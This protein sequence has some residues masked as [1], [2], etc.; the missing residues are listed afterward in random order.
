MN[1][2]CVVLFLLDSVTVSR[3][4][5]SQEI[6][7]LIG[8]SKGLDGFIARNFNQKSVLGSYLDPIS[9]KILINILATACAVMYLLPSWLVLLVFI[10]DALLI[11]GSVILARKVSLERGKDLIEQAA[12]LKLDSPLEIKVRYP[13]W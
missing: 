10:R 11:G 12:S 5:S 6:F 3:V 8:C 1:S 7:F 4:F 2:P 13:N 9:D